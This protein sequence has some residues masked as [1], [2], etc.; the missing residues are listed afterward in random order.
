M[1]APAYATY[2]LRDLDRDVDLASGLLAMASVDGQAGADEP[3][4]VEEIS[5][6]LDARR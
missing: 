4:F 6:I 1:D 2:S 5:A 3:V